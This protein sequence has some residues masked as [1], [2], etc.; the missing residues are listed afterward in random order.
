[1]SHFFKKLRGFTL[2][3]LL[4]VMAIIGILAAIGVAAYGG[5]QAKGR[6]ARRKSDLENTSKAL[7]VYYNDAGRYPTA[8]AGGTIAGV[9]WGAVWASADGGEVYM[10]QIPKD[11]RFEYYYESIN[12]GTAYRLY[13]RFE[14][15]QPSSG[16]YAGKGMVYLNEDTE[17]IE[18]CANG[19]NYHVRSSNAQK[20]IA[21][22]DPNST[23]EPV[24]GGDEEEEEE[25]NSENMHP[26]PGNCPDTCSHL[27]N[28][29]SQGAYQSCSMEYASWYPNPCNDPCLSRQ[30]R[31]YYECDT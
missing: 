26:I 2:L 27:L 22:A 12:G 6:D 18:G 30:D 20:P 14:N 15:D 1:M 5:V 4:V 9:P 24:F 23:P 7:E 10:A 25:D 16:N 13:A 29:P 28:H 21:T 17:I 19:C 11:P 8:G 31:N 3:E